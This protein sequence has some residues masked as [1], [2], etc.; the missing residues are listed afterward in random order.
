MKVQGL[1]LIRNLSK[2]VERHH[3]IQDAK[4]CEPSGVKGCG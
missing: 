2:K 4:Q 1:G 3:L